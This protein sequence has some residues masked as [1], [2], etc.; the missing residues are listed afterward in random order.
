MQKVNI[1]CLEL[2]PYQTPLTLA[3]A[4]KHKKKGNKEIKHSKITELTLPP[5]PGPISDYIIMG[6]FNVTQKSE[7]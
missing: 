4:H 1:H 2:I 6:L 3:L 7:N 5:V